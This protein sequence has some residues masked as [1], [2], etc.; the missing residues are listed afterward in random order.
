M[1]DTDGA[2][3]ALTRREARLAE[4]ASLMHRQAHLGPSQARTFLTFPIDLPGGTR[5]LTIR[6]RFSPAQVTRLRNLVTVSLFDPHGFRGAAHRHA[7]EQE[8]TVSLR[9]A[10]PGFL[11]GPLPA[12]LWTLE[13][14]LHAVLPS[15]RGGLDYVLEVIAHPG[16]VDD[17]TLD[18]EVPTAEAIEPS[19]P[20]E[21][22]L[23]PT[24]SPT[25]GESAAPAGWLKGDLHVHSNHS[26]GRW[27]AA[28]I[29][30]YARQ[31]R[32]DFLALT[33]HNTMSGRDDLRAAL[34]RAG[35]PTLI[36]DGMELTTFW[37]HANALGVA[38]WIDWRVAG[39][40]G[41]PERIG[42][43]Q[44]APP[45]RVMPEA[46]A[47]VHQ[48]GGLLVVNHPRSQGY[49]FCTGCHWDY[50]DETAGYADAI[51]VMNGPW[52]NKQNTYALALW[53]QWLNA[54]HRIPA[55]AGSDSHGVSR[56]PD[57]LG[58]TFVRADLSQDGIL[59][60]VKAGRTYLSRGPS[61][62]WLRPLP[63]NDLARDAT[64][65]AAHLGDLPGPADVWLVADGRRE[66]LSQ[67]S[68]AGE[69]R[70]ELDAALRERRWFRLEAC[71][72]GKKEL[73]ALTNPVW[74]VD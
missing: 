10:S 63:A 49:P 35:L 46:A 65:L 20:D 6:L 12:G 71:L 42:T 54:G 1:P 59:A 29:V 2:G 17:P 38:H 43:D 24:P 62:E 55:T 4:P 48:H 15:L 30:E 47:E 51:E 74:R 37:G 44:D 69:I 26:D 56:Q 27:M 8:L 39:P 31:N 58:F 68:A 34:R 28:D 18:D 73:L 60:A 33:D 36:I 61:L 3:G 32:L 22:P 72:R 66:R 7:P 9:E 16:A 64:S 19:A 52:S 67:P 23:P 57:Q 21:S 11:P 50:G 13:L 14:D 25:R 41:K 45:T 70:F 5:A 40:G 53:D